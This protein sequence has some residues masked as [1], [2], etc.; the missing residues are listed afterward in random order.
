MGISPYIAHLRRSIGTDLLL[1]PCVAVLPRDG[2][3]RVLLVRHVDSGQWATIGGTIEP[4]E[5][6]EDAARREALE[7]AG[8]AVELRGIIVATGGPRFRVTYPNGDEVSCVVIA[9][10]AVVRSGA[11]VPDHDETTEVAWFAIED[12]AS[13]DIGELNRQL[14][15]EVFAGR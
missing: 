8:I 7:E 12:L 6:P 9:Y 10:D 2:D 14:L 3:G 15:D 5:V 13:L 11:P 4:D 1:L